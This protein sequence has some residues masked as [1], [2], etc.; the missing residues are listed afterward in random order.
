MA[1]V[2]IPAGT[3][4]LNNPLQLYVG[5]V[6]MGDPT[7]PPT[8]ILA[9]TFPS[10]AALYCKDPRYNAVSSWYTAIKNIKIDSTR[11]D[12][13]RSVILIEWSV[14]LGCYI[15]NVVLNM[16]NY[17]TGHVGLVNLSHPNQSSL[18]IGSSHVQSSHLHLRIH[19]TAA[20]P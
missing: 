3:Y 10:A 8:I 12:V 20:A 19:C 18:T 7:N 11:V 9:S 14:G 4:L 6:L 1:V 15:T 5:T 17:S 13:A 16:P 2:Y